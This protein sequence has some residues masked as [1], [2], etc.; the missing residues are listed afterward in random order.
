MANI[1]LEPFT[2]PISAIHSLLIFGF[3]R[4]APGSTVDSASHGIGM[5]QQSTILQRP[6]YEGELPL[7]C[8]DSS[9]ILLAYGVEFGSMVVGCGKC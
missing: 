9:F 6:S 3:K 2:L 4:P 8:F 5:G 1:L 7:P